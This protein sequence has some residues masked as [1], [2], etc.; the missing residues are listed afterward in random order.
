[1][2]F[3]AFIVGLAIGCSVH[4]IRSGRNPYWI[5]PILV[6]PLVGSLAYLLVEVLPGLGARR[7]M[8]MAKA[9]VVR[10][11]DPDREVRAARDSLDLADTAAN[12]V[13][14]ADALSEQGKWDEASLHYREALA[15]APAGDRTSQLKLARARLEAG[16]GHDARRLLET[17]PESASAAENDRAAMLLA[18]ALAE[19]GDVDAAIALFDDIGKRMP[20]AEAQCRQAALLIEQGRDEDAVAPLAEAEARAKRLDRFERAK[21]RDMYEWAAATLAELRQKG[22]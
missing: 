7:E 19:C 3:L 13:D 11:I 15:K 1:M 22:P 16:D 6:F 17:L 5:L 4:C 14:L 10:K 9:E 2:L 21:H 20:G 18:R 8:R 12:R